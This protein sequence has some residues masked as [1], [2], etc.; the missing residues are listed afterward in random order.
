MASLWFYYKNLLEKTVHRN[1]FETC[2][3]ISLWLIVDCTDN[4][5]KESGCGAIKSLFNV[6]LARSALTPNPPI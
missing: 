2:L 5:S 1:G 4:P 6:F 3:T